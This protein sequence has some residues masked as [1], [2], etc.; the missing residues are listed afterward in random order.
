MD[1]KHERPGTMPG[2]AE[3]FTGQ[4]W[5][6][7][8]ADAAESPGRLQVYN[9]HFTPG[10]RTAWHQHD[11]GQVIYVTEGVGRAQ[12][13]GGPVREIRPGRLLYIHDSPKLTAQ[14]V[15]VELLK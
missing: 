14:Y 2:P 7:V 3:W 11:V 8:I 6:D 10:A 9:V 13:R 1:V 5:L 12:S 15:D 4:V